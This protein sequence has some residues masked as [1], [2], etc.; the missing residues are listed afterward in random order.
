MEAVA[1]DRAEGS[2]IDIILSGVDPGIVARDAGQ[3]WTTEYANRDL[4]VRSGVSPTIVEGGAVVTQNIVSFYRPSNIPEI[5]NMYRRMRDIAITQ[6]VL[7]NI[8]ANFSSAKWK[9]FTVVKDK[10]N[11]TVAR[12]RAMA[13]DID[14]VKND[15]LALINS[16]MSMAWL[17]DTEF[18]IQKLKEPDAVQVRMDGGG[19]N[20]SLFLIYSGE[21]GILDNTV[22]VDTSIAIAL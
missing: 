21:G 5:S 17:F 6:N 1:A 8:F 9:G 2:Y 7:Y 22:Y 18:S 14:D 3:D 20:N 11:V 10:A 4:A 12:N 13:R 19:F 15:D 16:F